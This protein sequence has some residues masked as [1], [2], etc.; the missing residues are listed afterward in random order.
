MKPELQAKV[1]W[2]S[3]NFQSELVAL[4]WVALIYI[5]FNTDRAIYILKSPW[6]S[7]FLLFSVI[8]SML[9]MI[10]SLKQAWRKL[11]GEVT[12]WGQAIKHV[13]QTA[14]HALQE[15]HEHAAS[16]DSK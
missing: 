15:A 5:W 2:V 4:V 13:K 6:G 3:A 8:V 9:V 16:N 7:A 10:W 1:R 11:A 12:W 14:A